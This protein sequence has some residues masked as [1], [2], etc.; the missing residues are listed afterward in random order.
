ML[1][2]TADPP[3]R[4]VPTQTGR[5]LSRKETKVFLPGREE[6][7]CAG[8]R[9]NYKATK[10]FSVGFPPPFRHRIQRNPRISLRYCLLQG[11]WIIHFQAIQ[12][13]LPGYSQKAPRSLAL[14]VLYVPYSLDSGKGFVAGGDVIWVG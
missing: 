6:G 9:G 14:T 13:N 1:C 10:G 5:G 11:L 4:R 12:K 7:V 2:R 8:R 3:V